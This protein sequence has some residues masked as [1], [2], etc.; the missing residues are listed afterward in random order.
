MVDVA[1]AELEPEL[2]G[3]DLVGGG[4]PAGRGRAAGSRRA[5]V[6]RSPRVRVTA[7]IDAAD[8]AGEVVGVA[9]RDL[10]AGEVQAQAVAQAEPGPA[11]WP[12]PPVTTTDSGPANPR[13]SGRSVSR[14]TKRGRRRSAVPR[15]ARARRTPRWRRGGGR[16]RAGRS[17]RRRRGRP[18]GR[19]IGRL[20]GRRSHG[21]TLAITHIADDQCP[22]IGRM[23]KDVTMA[24]YRQRRH[25]V[26]PKRH[27]Q[28]RDADGHL[29]REELMGE[30][31]FSSDS[32]LLYHRGVPSARSSTARSG[33]S[34]TSR[35][36]PTTRSSRA[37]SSCTTSRPAR[38]PV[39]GRRL[40]LGNNDVRIAYVVTG[41][42]PSPALPQRHRRRVRVR[43]ARHRHRRDRL[44][45]RAP[46][47][48]AT[49]S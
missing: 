25:A 48:P 16:R 35:A 36:R 11:T 44:R 23:Q 22:I 46:T 34:P 28:H 33:S 3:G 18:G 2:G 38:C 12:A 26:P 30:E 17:R 8:V 39:E 43:R 5:R 15:A 13:T 24:H 7:A 9:Q 10:E 40:V 27:T 1:G 32:S 37:T 4:E 31:G 41:T 20:A 45:R 29:Y 21:A 19:G 14:S 42:D 47:A 6:R 49:T